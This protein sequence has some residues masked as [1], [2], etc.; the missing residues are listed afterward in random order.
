M[1]RFLFWP[2]QGFWQYIILIKFFKCNNHKFLEPGHTY[3]DSDRDFA[4][5]FGD[6]NLSSV[7]KYQHIMTNSQ[8]KAN[9]ASVSDKITNIAS[10]PVLLGLKKQTVNELCKKD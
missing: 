10:L 4:K 1:E 5:V 6:V 3:L 2:E 9:G 8:S 7:D